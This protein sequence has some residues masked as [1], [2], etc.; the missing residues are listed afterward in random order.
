MNF[1]MVSPMSKGLF[2]RAI[3]QS[4]ALMMPVADPPRPGLAKMRAIRLSD[5]MKCPIINTNFKTMIECLR[6]KDAKKITQAMFDFYVSCTSEDE[7]F[8]TYSLLHCRSGITIRLFH[9]RRWL[10]T[11]ISRK[12]KLSYRIIVL[13]SILSTF[14][15]W[16]D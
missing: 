15:G 8:M 16:L 14:R 7:A 4:G 10:K 12:K 3:S 1:H 6:L 13:T 2:Q 9:F 11:R 5:K